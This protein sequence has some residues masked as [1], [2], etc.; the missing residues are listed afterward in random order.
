MEVENEGNDEEKE[1][2]EEDNEDKDDEEESEVRAREDMDGNFSEVGVNM[3][4]EKFQR[5]SNS[6]CNEGVL[7]NWEPLLLVTS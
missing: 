5:S 4:I 7:C 6:R 1:E 2:E 3:G